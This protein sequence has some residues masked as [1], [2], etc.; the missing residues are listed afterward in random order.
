ML[1]V[2][3]GREKYKHTLMILFYSRPLRFLR[4]IILNGYLKV[5]RFLRVQEQQK[6]NIRVFL[7]SSVD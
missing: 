4:T 2:R 6:I 3:K 7:R 5:T 1:H